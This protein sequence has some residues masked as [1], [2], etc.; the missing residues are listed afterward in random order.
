MSFVDELKRR[1]VFRVAL[2]YVATGWLLIQLADILFQTFR[3]PEWVM[4][5]FTALIALGF[6]FAVILAW[7]FELTPDG[8]K[9]DS[10]VTQRS[11]DLRHGRRDWLLIGI[12]VVAVGYRNTESWPRKRGHGFLPCPH[13]S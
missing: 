6:P 13:L 4:Q 10:E 9:R 12:I 3:S 1:N 2:V 7:A 5:S 8:I 11:A